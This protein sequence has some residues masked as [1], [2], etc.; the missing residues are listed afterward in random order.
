MLIAKMTAVLCL[1]RALQSL[2]RA[3]ATAELEPEAKTVKIAGMDELVFFAVLACGLAIVAWELVKIAGAKLWL[4]V[5][6]SEVKEGEE[7]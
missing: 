2:P 7:A 5:W 1:A 4:F 6:N 3:S